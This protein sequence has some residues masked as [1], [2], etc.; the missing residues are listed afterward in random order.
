[1]GSSNRIELS[2][3]WRD[4]SFDG[5]LLPVWREVAPGGFSAR[6]ETAHFGRGYPQ[7][8]AEH[9][10]RSGVAES[11]VAR[12]AVGVTLASPVDGYR[13]VERSLKYALLFMVL[14]F[15]G[16][17]GF[18]VTT[19]ARA[20][21]LQYLLSGA[22]LGLFYLGFLS[23]GEFVAPWMAYTGAAGASTALITAYAWSVLGT[24]R[25]ALTMGAGQSAVFAYLYFI[26]QLQDYAL[27]AGTAGLFL[28]LGG[29]MWLTRHVDWYA[30]D[31]RSAVQAGDSQRPPR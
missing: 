31:R 29:V 16:F 19:G 10:G 13:L 11:V 14:L 27:L 4:P 1:V 18:E 28:L 9:A 17:F 24:G 8:W 23:L 25:R 30:L 5:G 6:W 22:A 26:L 2:G 20:H 15:A 7:Q 3:A 12:S 21:P